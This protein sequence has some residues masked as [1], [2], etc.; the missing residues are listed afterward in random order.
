MLANKIISI[1]ILLCSISSVS[2]WV[3]EEGK[4]ENE[5]LV[6]NINTIFNDSN[7]NNP[8]F[9]DDYNVFVSPEI[10]SN[11]FIEFCT[12]YKIWKRVW[13]GTHYTNDPDCYYQ[14]EHCVD[15]IYNIDSTGKGYFTFPDNTEKLSDGYLIKRYFQQM[16]NEGHIP[17]A[18]YNNSDEAEKPDIFVF[19]V[20]CDVG[21]ND[22]NQVFSGAVVLN[23]NGESEL[24]SANHDYGFSMDGITAGGGGG[25][26]GSI[27]W[28]SDVSDAGHEAK[29]TFY[30]V[31]YGVI[32]LLFLI[33]VLKMMNRVSK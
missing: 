20:L 25:I 32:P 5:T 10:R 18:E 21:N 26:A 11:H 14:I 9:F 30:L 27:G 16:L 2:A 7:I 23:S 17:C 4:A 19:D 6:Y 15:T 22:L 33:S 1:L 12:E 24:K 29:N 3:S 13:N 31:F 8:V 28:G